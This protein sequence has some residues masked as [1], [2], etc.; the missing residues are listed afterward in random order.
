M[1]L[2]YSH[3]TITQLILLMPDVHLCT[4]SLQSC[5]ALC[6]P[7]YYSLP[8]CSVPGIL[9]A[10]IQEWIAIPSSRGSSWPRDRTC[11]SCIG[12][13]ILHHW[14]IREVPGVNIW[15]KKD[16]WNT[17]SLSLYNSFC[18]GQFC[19]HIMWPGFQLVWTAVKLLRNWKLLEKQQ[20][21]MK[22]SDKV[23]NCAL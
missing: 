15:G 23:Q 5:L 19:V 10:R 3:T 17:I 1:C 20:S 4:K 7:M 21:H 22:T 9:Q 14:A 8:G 6:D 13:Q 12:R 11:V 18:D 2:L 16:S